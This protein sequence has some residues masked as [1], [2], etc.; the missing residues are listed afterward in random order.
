MLLEV[1]VAIN[2]NMSAKQLYKDRFEYDDGLILE[3]VVWDLPMSVVGS[4][5]RYKYSLFYGNA[6]QGR[7]IGYDNERPKGDHRHYGSREEP[8]KLTSIEQLIADFMSDV[9]QIRSQK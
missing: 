5:H 7:L 6:E 9:K 3:I 8:Y 2:D 1:D 4:E